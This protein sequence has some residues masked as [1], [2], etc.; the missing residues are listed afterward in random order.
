MRVRFATEAQ[1]F[2]IYVIATRYALD[3]SGI[4]SRRERDFPHLSRPI[5]GPIQRSIQWVP[6]LFS[7]GV[8]RSVRGLNHPMASSAK[9]KERVELYLYSRSGTS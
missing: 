1:K 7:G 4:E 5:Q 9:V 8:K 3:V 2:V 6:F